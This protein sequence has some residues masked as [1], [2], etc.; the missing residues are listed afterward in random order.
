MYLRAMSTPSGTVVAVHRTETHEFSKQT[1]ES[2]T[3]LAGL[4][5]ES[6]AHMGARVKHRSR[7]A[8]DPNQPNLRQVHLV[9]SELLDEVAGKGYEVAPGALGENV[10]TRGLDLI[11]LPVG[12]TLRIGDALLAL[13]GLRN[14]CPQIRDLGEGLQSEMIGRDE[15]GRLL[16]K[17]GVMSVVVR[18]GDVRPGDE[19]HVA[20]PPGAPMPMEKI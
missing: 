18:G 4:G 3:L 1:R 6:D 14:P 10:T 15:N 19:I 13:T 8:R 9:A 11:R 12:T 20:F 5:V 2:I 7:V 17:T 16:L